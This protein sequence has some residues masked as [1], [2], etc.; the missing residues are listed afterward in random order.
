[1][2]FEQLPA[3]FSPE[4]PPYASGVERLADGILHVAVL[5]RMPG[6]SPRKVG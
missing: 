6:A 5:T 4:K 2:Q 3:L 1:M